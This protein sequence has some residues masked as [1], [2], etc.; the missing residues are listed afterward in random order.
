MDVPVRGG[1]LSTSGSLCVDV[2]SP[3]G[4][5]IEAGEFVVGHVEAGLEARIGPGSRWGVLGP[6]WG[7]IPIAGT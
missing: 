4:S 3:R 5:A 7:V 1:R 6:M 2:Y